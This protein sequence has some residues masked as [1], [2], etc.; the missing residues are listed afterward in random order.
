MYT[1]L[2]NFGST[3]YKRYQNPVVDGIM[4]CPWERADVQ[5]RVGSTA[6]NLGYQSK[7]C[8]Y[9]YADHCSKSWDDVCQAYYEGDQSTQFPNIL[10]S[11]LYNAWPN[12]KCD[13]GGCTSLT[14]G[15]RLLQTAAARAFCNYT[16]YIP[17]IEPMNPMD[18]SSY[19][20]TRYEIPAASPHRIEWN[21]DVSLLRDDNPIMKN[22]ITDKSGSCNIVLRQLV[23]DGALDHI[24]INESTHHTRNLLLSLK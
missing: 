5:F 23:R 14:G 13:D 18:S 4:M 9:F 22:C 16:G 15:Q 10:Q 24:P 20:Y 7:E 8:Q 1:K 19:K 21:R 12:M 3:E 17:V 11:Q 6:S 2:K